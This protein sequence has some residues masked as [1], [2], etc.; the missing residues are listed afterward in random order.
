MH[1][2]FSLQAEPLSAVAAA[3]QTGTKVSSVPQASKAT[4]EDEG[5]GTSRGIACRPILCFVCACFQY[6]TLCRCMPCLSCAVVDVGEL[7]D[8]DPREH[9]NLVFIGHVDAGKSTM[10]GQILYLTGQ[11]WR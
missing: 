5:A 2:C 6:Y 11:V 10:S 8:E 1:G 7:V 3:A 4:E 9:L